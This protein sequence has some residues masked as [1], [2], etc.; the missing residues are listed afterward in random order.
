MSVGVRLPGSLSAPHQSRAPLGCLSLGFHIWKSGVSQG[1]GISVAE[2]H[3][4]QAIVI[5]ETPVTNAET[6]FDVAKTFLHLPLLCPSHAV[7][8]CPR[9]LSLARCWPPATG[10]SHRAGVVYRSSPARLDSLDGAQ[11]PRFPGVNAQVSCLRAVGSG[12]T[13]GWVPRQVGAERGLVPLERWLFSMA[14]CF[15]LH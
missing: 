15:V 13:M 6:G 3:Q 9:N 8:L 10:E 1:R 12:L 14:L 4:C 7:L 11:A 2:A 5:M